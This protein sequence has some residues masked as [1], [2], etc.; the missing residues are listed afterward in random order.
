MTLST[1]GNKLR[2]IHAIAE[3]YWTA[4]NGS[5]VWWKRNAVE[6]AQVEI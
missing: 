3:Y 6:A 1:A 4:Q 2:D 5:R